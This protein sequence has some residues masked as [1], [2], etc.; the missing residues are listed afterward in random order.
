MVVIRRELPRTND[1]GPAATACRIAYREDSPL[2][3]ASPAA[4]HLRLNRVHRLMSAGGPEIPAIP[5]CEEFRFSM[6]E[7]HY[8]MRE[9]N[10][11]GGAGIPA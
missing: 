10:V 1:A 2:P 6:H 11:C 8:C 7:K 3:C 4:D 9:W 5:Q